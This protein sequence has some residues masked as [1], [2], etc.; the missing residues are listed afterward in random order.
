MNGVYWGLG[1][2]V[3]AQAD[4]RLVGDFIPSEYDAQGFRRGVKPEDLVLSA[5]S[6]EGR[7]DQSLR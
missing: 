4:V 2:E 6:E 3:P 1:L 7:N 5:K